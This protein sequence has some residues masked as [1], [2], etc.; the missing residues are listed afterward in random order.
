MEKEGQGW[1]TPPEGL[2]QKHCPLRPPEVR[3]VQRKW[4]ASDCVAHQLTEVAWFTKVKLVAERNEREADAAAVA[5]A[6]RCSKCRDSAWVFLGGLPYERTEGKSPVCSSGWEKFTRDR[7][8][9]V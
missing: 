9:G 8:T 5:R 7:K 4:G 2:H 1:D 6:A 3:I